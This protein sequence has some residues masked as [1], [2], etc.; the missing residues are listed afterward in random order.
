ML[1]DEGGKVYL[2]L[3]CLFFSFPCELS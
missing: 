1:L 2:V 3:E